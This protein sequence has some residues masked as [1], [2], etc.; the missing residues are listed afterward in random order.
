[1]YN[2]AIPRI[3]Y[4][5]LYITENQYSSLE[6]ASEDFAIAK[7][8][9]PSATFIQTSNARPPHQR[10]AA[11]KKVSGYHSLVVVVSLFSPLMRD[12]V[13]LVK[14]VISESFNPPAFDSSLLLTLNKVILEDEVPL[15]RFVR[16]DKPLEG[17]LR[18]LFRLHLF[19]SP[20]Y[21]ASRKT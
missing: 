17:F 10:R 3:L 11:L 13:V 19:I 20:P 1:M 12:N 4:A 21:Q 6:G 16:Q 15:V 7:M 18:F 9:T 14:A 8:T 5:S 2:I